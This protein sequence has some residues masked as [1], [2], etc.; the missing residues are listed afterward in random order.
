VKKIAF[1]DFDGTITTKDTMFEVIK[2]HKGTSDFYRGFIANIPVFV[3]L[4]LNMISNQEAKEKLLTYFF[5]DAPQT[6]FQTACDQFIDDKLPVLIRP[7]ASKEITKLKELGFEIVI[8]SASAE[9]WIKKW[10]DSQGVG[11]IATQLESVDGHLTGKLQGVN[12]NGEEKAVRI[13]DLYDRSQYDEIY[14]YGDSDG[15][16]Q[17][18]RMG[19]KSF[20]KPFR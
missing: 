7:G 11:L 14:V 6:S 9:N 15:D 20:F 10:A 18:M 4:K 2:H 17:M 13:R 5:K 1:F 3:K 19:T 16:R 12:C 8:V